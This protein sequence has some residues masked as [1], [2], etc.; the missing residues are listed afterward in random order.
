MPT[1]CDM[2]LCYI[3]RLFLWQPTRKHLLVTNSI[4]TKSHILPTSKFI[5]L[6]VVAMELVTLHTYLPA[7]S[8]PADG[9]EMIPSTLVEIGPTI[10]VLVGGGEDSDWQFKEPA[11]PGIAAHS[12]GVVD[13]SH[14]KPVDI[15]L[16]NVGGSA[17]IR[18][19][20]KITINF[21]MKGMWKRYYNY[22]TQV[23]QSCMRHHSLGPLG[24]F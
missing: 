19:N 22:A 6:V 15:S 20:Y 21:F 18:L 14:T 1:G 23:I 9:M 5:T 13:E 7:F 3:S 11:W 8:S 17:S 10:E 24:L 2:I 4:T 16:P 12:M